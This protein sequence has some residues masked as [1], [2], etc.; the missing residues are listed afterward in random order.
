ML[1]LQPKKRCIQ[2]SVHLVGHNTQWDILQKK[3]THSERHQW[4]SSV[5]C[6]ACLWYLVYHWKAAKHGIFNLNHV[7]V[8]CH[9]CDTPCCNHLAIILATK[10]F[11]EITTFEKV[12]RYN[13]F[14]SSKISSV[15]SEIVVMSCNFWSLLFAIRIIGCSGK[16]KRIIGWMSIH[17]AYCGV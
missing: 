15:H 4:H 5:V 6:E 3:N 17:R 7:S 9:G 10:K 13:M 8:V 12:K 14:S 1:K 16:K 2:S 11:V